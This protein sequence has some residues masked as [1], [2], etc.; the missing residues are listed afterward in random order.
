MAMCKG[1]MG[2]KLGMT[3]LFTPEGAYI[4]VTVV[5]LGPCVVTQIKTVATDGYNALQLG[6]GQRKPK[7][8]NKPMQGHLKKSGEQA[9]AYLREFPVENPDEYDLGQAVSLDLFS[10]GER[11]DVAGTTKGRG[12]SGVIKRHGFSRGPMTHGSKSIRIPGSIGCSAW[13]ARVIKGKKMPGHY[14]T[15]H[16]TVRNMKVVDIRPDENLM[17]LKGAV[18][19]PKNALVMI[20]KPKIVKK[21]A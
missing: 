3:G 11:V 15:E 20:S 12:F 6:F 17:L 10:I 4:P 8:V 7:Q 14:G 19:G 18:P 9:F 5:E 2:K 21:T 1:L 16:Q 13:P